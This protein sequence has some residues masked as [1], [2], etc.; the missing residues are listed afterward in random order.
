MRLSTSTC[1]YFNRPGGVKASILDSIRRC[2]EAGYRVLDMNF[3]DLCMFDTPFKT[4]AWETLMHDAARVA[5]EYGITFSQGHAHFY[6]FCDETLP[7]RDFLDE[8]IRRCIEGARILGVRWLVI[9]AATDFA[10]VTPWRDSK[11]KTIEYL[12]PRIELAGKYGVGIALENLWEENI[13][14]KRRYCVTAEELA[15]LVDSLPYPNVGCCWDVEHAAICQ[16]DQRKALPY[17]G[18]RL[19]ATHISDYNTV[20]N[21]HILPFSGLVDWQEVMDGLRLADYQ[22][23]FTY[24]IHNFTANMPEAGIMTALKHSIA[25]GNYLL[26]M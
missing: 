16:I 4:D 22:G 11:R 12:K 17:L 25:I 6:N 24:E 9:H 3:H 2:G 20:R 15:D 18:E 10:S 13:A 1:I 8:L 19:K 21:D 23:D 5:G 14:P 26:S 7:D